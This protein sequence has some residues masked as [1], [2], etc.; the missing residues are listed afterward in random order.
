MATWHGRLL[1]AGFPALGEWTHSCGVGLEQRLHAALPDSV[2]EAVQEPRVGA[3]R[4]LHAAP[5]CL[6]LH[7]HIAPPW[8]PDCQEQTGHLTEPSHLVQ[9]WLCT[10]DSRFCGGLAEYAAA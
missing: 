9:N 1:S 5:S 6:M 4:H 3:M 8:R 7:H 10:D 2:A